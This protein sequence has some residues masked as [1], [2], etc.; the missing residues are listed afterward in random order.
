MIYEE[1]EG[2]APPPEPQGESVEP[3]VDEPMTYRLDSRSILLAV[4][5][6]ENARLYVNDAET[7]STGAFRRFVSRGLRPGAT[8]TYTLRAEVDR[9]GETLSDVKTIKVTGGKA[10]RIAFAFDNQTDEQVAE[11][12]VV[13]TLTLNVPA[14]A[15]VFLA[16]Q[17]TKS[18]GQVR[19]FSTTRLTSEG[20]WADYPVRVELDRNGETLVRTASVSLKAGEKREL[21]ID[22][23]V[24]KVAR[25]E[26]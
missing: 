16:G 9:N 19:E 2:A 8:Y 6:P 14:E 18:D 3:S 1:S 13:T 23:D 12:P 21:T 26:N 24:E 17:P 15:K 25:A 4:T 7:K 5:V 10:T 11:K 20:Q 22:F